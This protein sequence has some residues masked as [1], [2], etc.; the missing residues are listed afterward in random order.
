MYGYIAQHIFN[1]IIMMGMDRDMMQSMNV[2]ELLTRDMGKTL[3]DVWV[4]SMGR[5]IC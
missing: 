2:W 4:H 5:L 3:V 1:G